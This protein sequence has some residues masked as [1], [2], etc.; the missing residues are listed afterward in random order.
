MTVPYYHVAKLRPV[1]LERGEFEGVQLIPEYLS[2][3]RELARE[4]NVRR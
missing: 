2:R 3:I 4:L 1:L